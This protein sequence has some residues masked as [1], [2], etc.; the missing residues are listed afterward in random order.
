[1]TYSTTYLPNTDINTG[2]DVELVPIILTA[3]KVTVYVWFLVTLILVIL[4]VLESGYIE[5]SIL[6]FWLVIG[7]L[8][9][10]Y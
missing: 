8:L 7:G 6:I 4:S 10:V 2:I 1:M 5:P 3:S 9:G